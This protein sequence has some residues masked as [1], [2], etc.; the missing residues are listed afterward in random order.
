[1]KTK[2]V[3]KTAAMVSTLILTACATNEESNKEPDKNETVEV[4]E[5]EK[6]N[7]K[8]DNKIYDKNGEVIAELSGDPLY[9]ADGEVIAVEETKKPAGS[10]DYNSK[11]DPRMMIPA[12]YEGFTETFETF[13]LPEERRLTTEEAEEKFGVNDVEHFPKIVYDNGMVFDKHSKSI[14]TQVWKE[15]ERP[16]PFGTQSLGF[17]MTVVKQSAIDIQVP[18]EGRGFELKP[19]EDLS[20]SEREYFEL[21]HGFILMQQKNMYLIHQFRQFET[22]FDEIGQD[23]LA[24]WTTK[25][26]DMMEHA[27]TFSRPDWEEVYKYHYE[28]VRRIFAMDQ[29]IPNM[30]E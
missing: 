7:P 11:N 9:F 29:S 14:T 10:G 1:M 26:V 20:T 3:L 2:N 6:V 4:A 12:G 16:Y 22:Y 24:S 5:T 19:L 18:W 8:S 30:W 21:G 28:A 25:T 13:E 27:D 23:E 17:F 15:E